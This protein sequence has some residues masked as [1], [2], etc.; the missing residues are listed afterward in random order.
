VAI[1]ILPL[2]TILAFL[3]PYVSYF[4]SSN[5]AVGEKGRLL[6]PRG[7]GLVAI[8]A[9]VDRESLAERRAS[10][11]G[12]VSSTGK[13]KRQI[14][15]AV[16]VSPFGPP[17]ADE[18]DKI[19]DDDYQLRT[20]RRRNRRLDGPNVCYLLGGDESC[21]DYDPL[22]GEAVLSGRLDAGGGFIGNEC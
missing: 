10:L 8:L 7:F 9:G 3:G 2:L 5:R 16:E 13:T 17:S 22:R 19:G 11:G 4:V 20:R 12:D 15:L 21:P 1:A 18:E 14:S 6:L